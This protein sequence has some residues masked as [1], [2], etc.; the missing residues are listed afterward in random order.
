MLGQHDV[1]VSTEPLVRKHLERPFQHGNLL[2]V[3]M[4]PSC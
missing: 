2:S 3:S 1:I 4:W